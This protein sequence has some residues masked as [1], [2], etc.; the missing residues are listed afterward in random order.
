MSRA[1]KLWTKVQLAEIRA[2]KTKT[3]VDRALLWSAQWENGQRDG[4]WRGREYE[5][6]DRCVT[7]ANEVERLRAQTHQLPSRQ[8]R[9]RTLVRVE[10]TF[11]EL[12]DR[13]VN[14]ERLDADDV[15]TA[16]RLALVPDDDEASVKC[17]SG[18]ADSAANPSSDPLDD[19]AESLEK[20]A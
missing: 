11:G 16:F 17:P 13:Q 10:A 1:D 3:K 20:D 6:E 18:D 15:I 4:M 14:G 12:F 8:L 7:L 19:P 9:E 5:A 2:R